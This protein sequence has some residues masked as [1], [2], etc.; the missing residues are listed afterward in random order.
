MTASGVARSAALNEQEL[1]REM[2]RWSGGLVHEQ[3]GLLFVAGPSSYLRVA[4]RMDAGVDGVAAVRR[5]G[6]SSTHPRVATSC[7][8]ASPTTPTSHG[9]RSPPGTPRRGPSA[10]MALHEP[11]DPSPLTGDVDVRV[12]STPEQVLDYGTGRRRGQR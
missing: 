2:V 9:P 5:A 4:I 12:V 1:W 3:D 7:S 11:P 10:P 8:S 6:S